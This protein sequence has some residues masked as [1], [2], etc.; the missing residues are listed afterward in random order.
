VT[1]KFQT[2]QHHKSQKIMTYSS[3][4]YGILT[5]LW[6]QQTTAI[7]LSVTTADYKT[8][9]PKLHHKSYFINGL[10]FQD[11]IL[12]FYDFFSTQVLIP[13]FSGPKKST[14]EFW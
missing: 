3:I 7:E 1:S 6:Q 5:R 4:M 2:Y 9:S 12:K 11:C 8:T 13:D 14:D 10:P